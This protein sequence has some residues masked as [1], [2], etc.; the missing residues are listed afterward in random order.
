ML[1]VYPLMRLGLVSLDLKGIILFSI[2]LAAN[3]I[4]WLN[5]KL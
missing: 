2:F 5:Y 1:E 3:S 4:N